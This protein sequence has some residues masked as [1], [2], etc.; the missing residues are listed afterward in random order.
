[1]SLIMSRPGLHTQSE[2]VAAANRYAHQLRL[3]AE[4]KGEPRSWA[5]CLSEAFKAAHSKDRA[6]KV[7]PVGIKSHLVLRATLDRLP[8]MAPKPDAV[9]DPNDPALDKLNFSP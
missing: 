7:T 9:P 5:S 2:R 3:L 1:M 4:Q 8:D 6:W